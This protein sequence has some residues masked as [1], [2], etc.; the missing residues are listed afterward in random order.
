MRRA[1]R[2]L[3]SDMAE[4]WYP[5]TGDDTSAAAYID[6]L[7][8]EPLGPAERFDMNDVAARYLRE[9]RSA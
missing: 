6:Q 4:A 3:E 8:G 7:S 9:F 1:R 2:A 5:G